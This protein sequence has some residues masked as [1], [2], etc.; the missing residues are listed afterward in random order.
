MIRPET[1]DHVSNDEEDQEDVAVNK[2][3]DHESTYQKAKNMT[4]LSRKTG[5]D[6]D[7]GFTLDM[8]KCTKEI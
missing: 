6:I 2:S 4:A 5:E 3:N 8:S 1:L 7:I